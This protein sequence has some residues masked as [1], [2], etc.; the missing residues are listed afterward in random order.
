M[1]RIE[2][3]LAV[4]ATVLAVWFQPSGVLGCG[5]PSSFNANCSAPASTPHTVLPSP[6]PIAGQ[7]IMNGSSPLT[8]PWASP[9]P[10]SDSGPDGAAVVPP[11][12]ADGLASLADLDRGGNQWGIIFPG[13]RP[14]PEGFWPGLGALHPVKHGQPVVQKTSVA[15]STSIAMEVKAK[16]PHKGIPGIDPMTSGSG[17]RALWFTGAR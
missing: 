9:P 1:K 14:L 4:S 6:P 13:A 17:N 12:S 15:I 10:P 7:L 3:V 11:S 2:L 5:G 16:V 8:G